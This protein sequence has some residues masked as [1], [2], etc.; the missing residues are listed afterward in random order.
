MIMGQNNLIFPRN[1]KFLFWAILVLWFNVTYSRLSITVY[2]L[3]F[4]SP[5]TAGPETRIWGQVAYLKGIPV[6]R[7]REWEEWDRTEG[8]PYD[9]SVSKQV[10]SWA[11]GAQSHSGTSEE[12]HRPISELPTGGQGALSSDSVTHIC[13]ESWPCCSWECWLPW[14]AKL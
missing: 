8:K 7:G 4:R 6:S 10:T 12:L 11:P 1:I 2:V 5:L 13:H 9:V 14:T 3:K